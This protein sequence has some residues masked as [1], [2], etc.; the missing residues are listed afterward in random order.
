ML[1]FCTLFE[2]KNNIA[3]T[4]LNRMERTTQFVH[5]DSFIVAPLAMYD[6]ATR[7]S[8]AH[9]TQRTLTTTLSDSMIAVLI[10]V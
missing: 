8:H 9:K 5:Q 10:V 7:S 4:L 2:K 3:V 1:S 6:F